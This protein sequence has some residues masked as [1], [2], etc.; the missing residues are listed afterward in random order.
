VL[1]RQGPGARVTR[2]KR[3]RQPD[4]VLKAP[5]RGQRLAPAGRRGPLWTAAR[6]PRSS[7]P[8]TWRASSTA[9]SAGSAL[10]P[11]GGNAATTVSSP[12][13]HAVQDGAPAI[14]VRPEGP[15]RPTEVRSPLSATVID[16]LAEDVMQRI[17]KRLRIERERRGL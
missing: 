10:S 2:K 5:A 17:E 1:V 6:D 16:R 11:G 4:D 8:F 13:P 15:A 9:S 14:A 12:L 7:P 3:A